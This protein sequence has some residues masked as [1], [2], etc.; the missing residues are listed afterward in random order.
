MRIFEFRAW[1]GEYMEYGG[2]YIHASGIVHSVGGL[3]NVNEYSPIMLYTGLQDKHG[4]KI[5]QGDLINP[6]LREIR[7]GMYESSEESEIITQGNGFYTLCH[8]KKWLEE[9]NYLELPFSF[10]YRQAQNCEVIGNIYTN[11]EV[12]NGD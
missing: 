9:N 5:F 8:N 10:S 12:M 3:S 2:F 1:N 11:P 6:N 4:A 7:F